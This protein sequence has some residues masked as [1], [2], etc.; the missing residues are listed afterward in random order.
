M[1]YYSLSLRN[2]SSIMVNSTWTKDHVNAVLDYAA[3][4]IVLSTI[5]SIIVS[6]ACGLS[7]VLRTG[8]VTRRP[9][10]IA[11]PSCDTK[12]M[13]TF[14]LTGRERIILSLAQFR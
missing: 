10:Q 1:F 4:D 11:Y 14:P 13:S 5:H 8:K 3:N 7:T 9:I 6:I 12:Q 2:A